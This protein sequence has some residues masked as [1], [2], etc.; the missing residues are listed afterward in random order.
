MERPTIDLAKAEKARPRRGTEFGDAGVG[1][2]GFPSCGERVARWESFVVTAAGV[3]M[4]RACWE[5]VKVR[6]IFTN[7]DGTLKAEFRTPAASKG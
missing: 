6:R 1:E 7:A 5:R 3:L 4:H 2:C